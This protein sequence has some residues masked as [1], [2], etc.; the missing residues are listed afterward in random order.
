MLLQYLL[1]ASTASAT[2]LHGL[3]KFKRAEEGE[4]VQVGTFGYTGLKGPLNWASLAPENQA[5]KTGKQQSPI[6]I[7]DSISLATEAPVLDIP[8]Q[9][10]EFENLGTTVEVIV[11]GT[12]KFAGQ[13]FRLK[14][15]HLHTPSEHRIGEEYFPLEMHMVHEG[16]TDPNALAVISVLF[17]LCTGA[18][19]PLIAGL[20]PHLSAI[21]T[22]GTKTEIESLD[23]EALIEHVQT[24]PLFQYT[25]SL[26]TPP[27]EEG[28]TFL[29]TKEPLKVDVE[30]F[31]AIKGVVK[32]NSRYT[33]NTLGQENLIAVAGVAGT[34]QQFNA[35]QKESAPT[36]TVKVE[37]SGPITKGHTL[38]ITE[39]QGQPTSLLGVVVKKN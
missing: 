36:S 21:A 29:V 13:D 32:F 39:I 27:C 5:C 17:Q 2:C 25:G 34:D 30:T 1:L 14:Q 35:E 8:E 4:G 28:L 38:V 33:Q 26:T 6:N 3:T 18:P 24:T 31:N 10:V 19:S 20:Q 12:T 15:F 23:F 9:K 7:D 22:P 37:E 16:V 11:N